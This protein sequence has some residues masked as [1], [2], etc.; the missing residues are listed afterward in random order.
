M[1]LVPGVWSRVWRTIDVTSAGTV[2]VG[3]LAGG[4]GTATQGNYVE[5]DSFS[6]FEGP[7]AYGFYDGSSARWSWTGAPDASSSF[8]PAQAL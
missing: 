5:L 6:L 7:N 1:T 2:K 8:G 4:S 3:F